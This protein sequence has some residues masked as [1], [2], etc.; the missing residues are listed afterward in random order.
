[1]MRDRDGGGADDD[2]NQKDCLEGQLLTLNKH[3]RGLDELQKL[4]S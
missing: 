4:N 3:W 1:M 2:Q